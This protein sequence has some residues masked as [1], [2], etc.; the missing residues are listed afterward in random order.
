VA[1]EID[2]IIPIRHGGTHDLDN[3]RAL[4][5][6]C[7]SSRGSGF[8]RASIITIRTD[9]AALIAAELHRQLSPEVLLSVVDLLAKIV[10]ED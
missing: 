1:L 2:H 4:C 7:N 10:S 8:R 3:L 9:S 5:Q 6:P